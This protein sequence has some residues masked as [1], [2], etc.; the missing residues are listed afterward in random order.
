MRHQLINSTNYSEITARSSG[1]PKANLSSDLC[2]RPGT[3]FAGAAQ[4]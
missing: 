1:H 3:R 4:H 2:T